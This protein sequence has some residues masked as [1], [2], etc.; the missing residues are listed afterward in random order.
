ML[1][2]NVSLSDL[3]LKCGKMPDW[4]K[5]SVENANSIKDVLE[6]A[7]QLMEDKK[8]VLLSRDQMKERE[9]KGNGE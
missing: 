2:L 9:A 8:K 3:A 5:R 1:L 4:A 6:A 7:K